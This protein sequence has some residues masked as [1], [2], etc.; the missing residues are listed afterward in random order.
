MVSRA[1]L[2]QLK[3]EYLGERMVVGLGNLS[4]PL[5]ADGGVMRAGNIELLAP[6]LVVGG[7][8]RTWGFFSL[9]PVVELRVDECASRAVISAKAL[10]MD[11]ATDVYWSFIRASGIDPLP[12]DSYIGGFALGMMLE[13]AL[14]GLLVHNL[15]ESGRVG[16]EKSWRR[17]MY[18]GFLERYRGYNARRAFLEAQEVFR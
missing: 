13:S 1:P 4:R 17:V 3:F 6:T 8:C 15:S 18:S 5:Q 11:N 7:A 10:N 14:S 9:E 2:E 12:I 16:F